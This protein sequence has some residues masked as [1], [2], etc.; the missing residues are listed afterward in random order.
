MTEDITPSSLPLPQCPPLS[1]LSPRPRTCPSAADVWCARA[2]APCSCGFVQQ[3]TGWHLCCILP[4]ISW[5]FMVP[6]AKPR[7]LQTVRRNFRRR[8]SGNL[9][10]SVCIICVA[11]L[12]TS[13]ES[14]GCSAEEEDSHGIMFGRSRNGS[15]PT[16]LQ[17]PS[18]SASHCTPS[19]PA[20]SPAPCEDA[21]E[22]HLFIFWN[23]LGEKGTRKGIQAVAAHPEL[24]ILE[25]HVKR[26]PEEAE[27]FAKCH[28][29]FYRNNHAE[30]GYT[31]PPQFLQDGF[32]GKV[33]GTGPFT[34][35]LAAVNCEAVKRVAAAPCKGSADC[36]NAP[37]AELLVFFKKQLRKGLSK[38][39]KY[40]IHAT[41]NGKE[42]LHDVTSLF[43][44][45][46][47]EKLVR[48]KK[49]GERWNDVAV[50]DQQV[51]CVDPHG[52]AGQRSG[53][54]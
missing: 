3:G 11:P 13:D 17:H 15:S 49:A 18:G 46:Y 6:S 36:D 26:W 16:L 45:G 38:G 41:V 48:Q 4:A 30:K 22:V 34:V 53:Q 39:N 29:N 24:E 1:S 27:A 37:K 44:D 20:V 32:V 21:G 40:A 12:S 8:T 23:S 10:K 2:H 51:S 35:V 5:R 47:Y 28:Q 9:R 54:R 14:Q 25:V 52:A 7:V 19:V 33:K 50:H 43:G 31:V 42:A